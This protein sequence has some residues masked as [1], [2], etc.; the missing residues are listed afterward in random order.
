MAMSDSAGM[1]EVKA[2][3]QIDP[4]QSENEGKYLTF[5]L[6]EEGYGIGILKVREIIGMLPVTPVPQTPGFLKGVIN[7]RGQVIPV[8]DLRLKFGLR[9]E[10]YTERTSIIV[11]EVKG[12]ASNIPIG[13]VV[14]TV[15]EVINIQAQD[16][17][18]APTF[19]SSVSTNFIL[20]MAKTEGGVKILLN[21]DQVLSA[22]ELGAL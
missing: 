13:I 22:E 19:G 17:E 14:D 16:I 20:G 15:S 6:A 5:Q 11:V 1:T 10:D 21:I 8:V 4:F 7:L 3:A 2:A 9:E 18:P 12:L